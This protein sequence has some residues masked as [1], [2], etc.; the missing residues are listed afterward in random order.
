MEDLDAGEESGV[1]GEGGEAIDELADDEQGEPRGERMGAGE[2]GVE[3]F[4]IKEFRNVIVRALVLAAFDDAEQVAVAE[5]GGELDE[6][7][8]AGGIPLALGGADGDVE[9]HEAV[10]FVIE[11]ETGDLVGAAPDF[12]GGALTILTNGV[13]AEGLERHGKKAGGGAGLGAGRAEPGA[14][15]GTML[16]RSVYFRIGNSSL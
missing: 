11:G 13:V 8:E 10:L 1:A 5:G 7:E 15:R 16:D 4:T 12:D 6:V 14:G 3:A 9:L 2:P